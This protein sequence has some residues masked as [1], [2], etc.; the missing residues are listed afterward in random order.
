MSM[1]IL[2]EQISK[3]LASPEPEVL[4]I[5]GPWGIGKTFTWN[6]FLEEERGQIALEKYS[7]VSLFGINSLDSLK[8]SIFEQTISR[9]LIGKEPDYETFLENAKEVL[10]SKGVNLIPLIKD[11]LAT[12]GFAKLIDSAS[13]LYIGKT[14]IC[15][16]DF[17]RKGEDLAL[18]DVLGLVSM[19]KEQR[20]CKMVLIFNNEAFENDDSKE[21]EKF[22]EK[23]I[24]VELM[25]DLSPSECSELAL[26]GD[27]SLKKKLRHYTSKLGI[28]NIRILKKIER[29]AVL[30]E[31]ILHENYEPE[32]LNQVL[33]SLVLFCQCF[34]SKTPNFPSF[35]YVKNIGNKMLGLS[36]DNSDNNKNSNEEKWKILLREY[37][38]TT[39]DNLDLTIANAVKAGYFNEDVLTLE[40]KKINNQ[41]ISSKSEQS[42]GESWNSYHDSFDDD[43]EKVVQTL[44]DS[45]Y[46]NYKNITPLN[47]DGTVRLFR[48]L[49]RNE[50]AN[51]LISY[52]IDKRKNEREL[53]DL[54]NSPFSS[55]IKDKKIRESFNQLISETHKEKPLKEILENIVH[56]DGWNRDDED[57]LGKASIEEYYELFK[58]EKGRHLSRLVNTCLKFSSFTN[59]PIEA[60]KRISK[61]NKLN[62]RRVSKYGINYDE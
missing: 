47:L 30:A 62:A 10:Y 19:L 60:L 39:T 21:Y 55:E 13:L 11:Y 49:D 24:D 54:T 3:F 25:F 23:A 36:D 14:I 29:L 35:D 45:F 22:R 2:K 48:D 31:K 58:N 46:K 1:K 38:Y 16:D 41:I 53:F 32:V 9:K 59:S 8:S 42:F 6:K 33:H 57:I 26:S 15:I 5:S 44:K 61:E 7:Y 12:K 51:E 20:K 17:E 52:Y 27:S 37:D 56:K 43:E 4:A 18:R 40:A 28:N 34:Y 50:L